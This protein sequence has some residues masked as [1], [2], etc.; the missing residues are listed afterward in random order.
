MS[1]VWLIPDSC[2]A[3]IILDMQVS[4]FSFLEIALISFPLGMLLRYVFHDI[5]IV[6]VFSLMYDIIYGSMQ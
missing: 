4:Y 6:E 5:N 3:C 2:F 1:P